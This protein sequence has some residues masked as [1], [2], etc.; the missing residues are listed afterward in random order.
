M[1]TTNKSKPS[2]AKQLES[3]STG[4]RLAYEAPSI[5]LLSLSA[6][7][8]GAG[9]SQADDDFSVSKPSGARP[10]RRG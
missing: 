3:D 7:I 8:A 9:G 5:S 6:V 10:G 2:L 1:Q 4:G